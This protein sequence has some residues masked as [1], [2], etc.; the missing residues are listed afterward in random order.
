MKE[1]FILLILLPGFQ[2]MMA[3]PEALSNIVKSLARDVD[4]SR[5]AVALL[6]LLSDLTKVRQRIGKVQGCIMML[7]T[8]LNG[9]DPSSSYD[10]GKLLAS[11]SSNTQNVLLMAEAGFFVPLV[12]YLKEGNHEN[13]FLKNRN[14]EF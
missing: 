11:L 8:L 14:F 13:S 3:N 1:C 6:L 10:A 2:E 5:E 12:Q 9:S 4:E 7:V